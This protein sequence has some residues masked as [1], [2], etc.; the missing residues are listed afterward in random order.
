LKAF[1]TD[2]FVLPLPPGHRFPMEKYSR[3]RDLVGGEQALELVEAPAANDTQIL[4]AHDPLYLIKI[5][6][7]KGKKAVEQVV[8]IP[9]IEIKQTKVLIKF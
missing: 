4:Y 3:L 6:E 5:I 2:H 9:F 1:Y 8:E 7:G